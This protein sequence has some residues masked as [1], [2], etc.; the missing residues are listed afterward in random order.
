MAT[1]TGIYQIKNTITGKVYV[2]SAINI[3]NRFLD[4]KQLLKRQKHHSKKLQHSVNKYGI[5]NFVFEII[6]ECEKDFL[7]ERE[8]YYINTYESYEKGYNATPTAGSKLGFKFSEESKKKMRQSQKGLRAGEKHPLYGKRHSEETKRKISI[9]NSGKKASEETKRKMSKSRKGRTPAMLGKKHSEET[10]RKI[11]KANEDK[12]K[13]E[14]NPSSKLNDFL[15]LEI[16]NLWDQL[17]P[18]KNNLTYKTIM[19]FCEKY[20]VT[21]STIYNIVKRKSWIHI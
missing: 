20:S 19:L 17:K 8:Q 11:S 4:H 9:K 2:G 6:E 1:K 10:K 7:I 14:K 16:R 21:Y 18:E 12:L 3:K 15:V 13:G 5:E